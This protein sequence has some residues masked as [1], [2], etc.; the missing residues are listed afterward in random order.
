MI[1]LNTLPLGEPICLTFNVDTKQQSLLD[2]MYKNRRW[3]VMNKYGQ[4]VFV[5]TFITEFQIKLKQVKR[6]R[7]NKR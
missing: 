6:N 5:N 2:K 7:R 4:M 3:F 1:D